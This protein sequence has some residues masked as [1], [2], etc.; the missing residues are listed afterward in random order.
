ERIACALIATEIEIQ[1]A[2]F[3]I[4]WGAEGSLYLYLRCDERAGDPLNISATNK[5]NRAIWQGDTVALLIET[6]S[7]SY[8]E[9]AVNPTGA[10][11]DADFSAGDTPRYD[12]DSQAEVAVQASNDCWT[13]EMRI[14]VTQ[15]ENDPLHNVIGRKPSSSLPWHV[16]I[17]RQR[18]RTNGTE[19]TAF[20]PT[21]SDTWRVPLKFGQL[22][23]GKSHTFEAADTPDDFLVALRAAEK[24]GKR[25]EAIDAF[26]ALAG[27][28]ITDFQKSYVLEQA[29][30]CARSSK[31]VELANELAGRIPVPAVAKTVRMQNLLA[32]QKPQALADEFGK[33]DISA[34][35][36]WK[37][38][39]GY[40]AR[41][42]AWSA[43]KQ[44]KEA[45]ADL[46]KALEY[47]TDLMERADIL[48]AIAENRLANLEDLAGATEAYLQVVAMS[49]LGGSAK[50]LGAAVRCAQLLAKQKKYAEAEAVLDKMNAGN[51]SGTWRG[52]M[53]LARAAVLDAAGK[54]NEAAAACR[55]LIADTNM[56]PAQIKQ[57][58]VFIA[59]R[60][61]APA[62]AT[63]AV[64][65]E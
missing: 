57:A 30:D 18:V 16:N 65:S 22:F 7:H 50:Y 37:Q 35:P 10:V 41:G 61:N 25:A 55:E 45:E 58:E 11:C 42:R 54:T 14:P 29:A 39:D 34:W 5:D 63:N 60:T 44:G 47:P 4:G 27:R 33:E 21:G 62:A 19:T 2:S 52:S 59:A 40:F 3:K 6:D 46:T 20:S 49:R 28:P 13:V 17:V 26:T 31:K 12:W 51:L 8:Y 1:T 53:L 36:F 32:E 9:I 48:Q 38:R 43:L 23:M 56:P 24:Q 15:D 64:P